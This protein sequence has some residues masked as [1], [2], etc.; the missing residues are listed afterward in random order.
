MNVPEMV[1]KV[2]EDNQCPLYQ[3]DDIF[4][5]SG[6]SLKLPLAKPT[7]MV[8]MDDIKEAVKVSEKPDGT[9]ELNCPLYRFNCSGPKNCLV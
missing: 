6:R 8:L 9:Y 2:I 7:C 4:N 1:F 5:L 3:L